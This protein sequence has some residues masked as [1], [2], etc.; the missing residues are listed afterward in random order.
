M[1]PAAVIM[2]HVTMIRTMPV[3]TPVSTMT[4]KVAMSRGKVMRVV[5]MSSPS[6][7]MVHFREDRCR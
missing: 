6:M 2:T 4:V 1:M 3:I 7:V 5:M